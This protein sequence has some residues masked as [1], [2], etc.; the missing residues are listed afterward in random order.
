MFIN[1]QEDQEVNGSSCEVSDIFPTCFVQNFLVP[2]EG[3][4][5]PGL[6]SQVRAGQQQDP[7][8]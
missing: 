8:L 7:Y 4:E 3:P 2:G 1:N 6:H 5:M